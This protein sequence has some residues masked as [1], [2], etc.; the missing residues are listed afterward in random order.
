MWQWHSRIFEI[1][2]SYFSDHIG[3]QSEELIMDSA[4]HCLNQSEE[5]RRLM[6]LAQNEAEAQVLRNLART[7]SGLAG[8]IDRYDALIRE[9]RRAVRKFSPEVPSL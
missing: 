7:W 1:E 2:L 8:Q 3:S 4:Q 9:Q 5:C 6:K